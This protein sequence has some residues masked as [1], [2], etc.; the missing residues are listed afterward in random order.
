MIAAFF[1]LTLRR[2]SVFGFEFRIT[3][4]TGKTNLG[5]ALCPMR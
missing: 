4:I 3:G 1:A 5:H 2:L